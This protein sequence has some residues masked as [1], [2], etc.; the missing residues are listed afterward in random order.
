MLLAHRLSPDATVLEALMDMH[1][2][3]K[4]G[5]GL[6]AALSCFAVACAA[7]GP[8]DS[9][10]GASSVIA[11]PDASASPSPTASPVPKIYVAN[12]GGGSITIYPKGA[13]GNVAPVRTIQGPD[14]DLHDPT[15]IAVDSL[16]YIYVGNIGNTPADIDV[17]RPSAKGDAVPVRHITPVAPHPV[18]DGAR[19]MAVDAVNDLYVAVP[20]EGILEYAAGAKGDVAPIATIAG[21]NVVC[22][23]PAGVDIDAAGNIW[24]ADGGAVCEYPSGSNGNVTPSRAIIGDLTG[25]FNAT[26][27]KVN[28]SDSIF[29]SPASEGSPLLRFAS[30]AN[31]NVAPAATIAMPTSLPTPYPASIALLGTTV[32]VGVGSAQSTLADGV[33]SWAQ[34]ANGT[35]APKRLITGNNTGM[36]ELFYIAIH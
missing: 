22:A 34:T 1:A 29:V 30:T 32:Y 18:L 7:Q 33:A 24:A 19:G 26:D 9:R 4:I 6:A 2:R 28:A 8:N 10:F 35:P 21:S 3:V 20:G 13:N 23:N 17:Y 14:T 16:G 5:F 11:H 31:G 12:A 15:G 25:L 27:V 36:V